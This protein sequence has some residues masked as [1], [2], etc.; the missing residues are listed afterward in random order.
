MPRPRSLLRGL[1]ISLRRLLHDGDTGP[2]FEP[3]GERPPSAEAR[4]GELKRHFDDTWVTSPLL[5]DQ[6]EARLSADLS[7]NIRRMQEAWGHATDLATRRFLLRNGPRAALM[8][9]KGQIDEERLAT[10][11]IRPLQ[12]APTGREGPEGRGRSRFGVNGRGL[13]AHLE[14]RVESGAMLNETTSFPESV[15]QIARGLALLLVDGVPTAVAINVSRRPKRAITEPVT[16]PVIRGPREG[17]IEN[18]DT[19]VALMRS[20]VRHPGLRFLTYQI[21]K[22]S[23]TRVQALYLEDRTPPELV[24]EMKSRLCRI[25]I[26]AV[27]ESNYIEELIEDAPYSPF[28]Q[29]L[30]TERPDVA[31]AAL[32]EGRMIV[33]TDG[34]PFCLIAPATIWMFLQA[35]EDYYQHFLVSSLTRILRMALAILSVSLPAFYIAAVNFHPGMIPTP[36]LITIAAARERV[37]LP[38]ALEIFL[39]ELAFEAFREAGVRL[40]RVVGQTVSIVGGLIIGQAAVQAGL[41][42]APIVVIVALTGIA[43][44]AIPH[45]ALTAAFRMLRFFL[46]IMASTYGLFGILIGGGFIMI[47]LLTI[48]SFGTPYMW[49]V[50]PLNIAALKDTF[51]R[52]PF[53][54][55]WSVIRPKGDRAGPGSES[56][57]RGFP[58]RPHAPPGPRASFG[59]QPLRRDDGAARDE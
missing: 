3:T 35:S 34:T 56:H 38:A 46:M 48:R 12:A 8:Y 16:E 44:F 36:L 14:E 51:I 18:L 42:S 31:A 20:R 17:F 2:A 37:P 9:L 10:S 30:S 29:I 53:W 1:L 32:Y 24:Q 13:V 28:P 4:G 21:G 33:L 27:V 45:V 55:M 43:T 54:H 6:P 7:R 26:D 5:A 47:H 57:S 19:N 11:V 58:V 40:P 39:F 23:Q 52:S 22:Y 25:E 59:S 41:I 15:N 50:A 49:P